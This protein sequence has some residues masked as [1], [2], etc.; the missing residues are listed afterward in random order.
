MRRLGLCRAHTAQ[1]SGLR[2]AAATTTG[3]CCSPIPSHVSSLLS[4]APLLASFLSPPSP[5]GSLPL[6][7]AASGIYSCP[8]LNFGPSRDPDD[9]EYDISLGKAIDVLRVDYSKS[10]DRDHCFNCDIY[11]ESVQLEIGDP[12]SM[13]PV[14]GKK[15]YT[16][17][18]RGLRA[19]VSRIVDGQVD[20]R[21][22]DKKG[23]P[24]DWALKFSWTC[25]GQINIGV[26]PM[27]DFLISANSLYDLKRQPSSPEEAGPVMKHKI[28][29]HRIEF[30]EIEPW[31]LKRHLS[32]IIPMQG[33]DVEVAFAIGGA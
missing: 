24:P 12:V 21:V 27:F 25:K 15:A 2:L 28:H 8:F 30:T 32:K 29:R 14:R 11:D 23:A 7:H 5:L 18:L 17:A 10:F 33:K 9:V 20:F 26:G 13:K 19:V 16:T 22:H 6:S 31:E 3:D 1:P 4:L